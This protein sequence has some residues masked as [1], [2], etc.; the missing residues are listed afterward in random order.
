MMR[1]LYAWWAIL[2]FAWTN[3]KRNRMTTGVSSS[4]IMVVLWLL[5]CW[6]Q[7][8][9]WLEAWLRPYRE[10]FILYVYLMD[11]AASGQRSVVERWLHASPL[12]QTWQFISP[13]E[14]RRRFI[15]MFPEFQG[16]IDSL[17]TNPLP[18]HYEVRLAPERVEA[19]SLR[20]LVDGLQR[21]PGVAGVDYQQW[22]VER[23]GTLFRVVRWGGLVLGGVLAGMALFTVANVIRL[24]FFARREE[25][26]I[27]SLL[28]AHPWHVRLPFY[29]EGILLGLLGSLMA[30]VLWFLSLQGA[31]WYLRKLTMAYWSVQV[32][33]PVA[34]PIAQW[35]L[36]GG[37]LLGFLGAV[38][39]LWMMRA[40]G[41]A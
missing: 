9:H 4:I 16:L 39:A 29:L 6:L 37:L 31:H 12:V 11:E 41:T 18:A 7:A 26:Q 38:L 21:L 35:I 36:A 33:L 10:S 2:Q 3:L 22:W 8:G 34:Y 20:R 23:L 32:Q 15:E 17:Q 25:V 28:G 27:L 1:R 14:A 13:A 24:S 30:T 19:Q 5:G 40:E